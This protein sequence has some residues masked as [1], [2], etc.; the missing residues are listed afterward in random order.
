MLNA[1]NCVC[2][3]FGNLVTNLVTSFDYE[4][5]LAPGAPM[6]HWLQA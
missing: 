4:P 3:G 1:R 5:D 2:D 6:E